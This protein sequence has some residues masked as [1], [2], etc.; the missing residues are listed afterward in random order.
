VQAKNKNQIYLNWQ[1]STQVNNKGFYVQY[2]RDQS[3]WDDLA[4]IPSRTVNS[5]EAEQYSYSYLASLS[6]SNF[7]RI[8]QEDLDGK[9]SY[10]WVRVLNATPENPVIV[11]PN[12]A[13]D[14]LNVLCSEQTVTQAQIVD[15][16]G[17]LIKNFNVRPGEN[18]VDISSLKSGVYFIFVN[19][20]DGKRNMAKM[21]K[22]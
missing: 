8:K 20:S 11:Y 7:Y 9:S 10:S 19:Q 12:P 17:R 1:V 13:K 3:K 16:S 22:Q 2:S 18:K 14:V 4:Y 6:V 15:L 21:V 5:L